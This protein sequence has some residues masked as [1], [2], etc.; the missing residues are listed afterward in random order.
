M[1]DIL[2]PDHRAA[3]E[4]IRKWI[5]RVKEKRPGDSIKR[6]VVEEYTTE[7]LSI[8]DSL[9]S[10]EPKQYTE[11][12]LRAMFEHPRLK[13]MRKHTPEPSLP[14]RDDGTYLFHETQVAWYWYLEAARDILGAL[15]K[16]RGE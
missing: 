6:Y 1:K 7:L 11:D 16:D 3:V 10:P 9:K 15:K 5:K 13:A 2:T 4:R 8:L 12:E 14:R